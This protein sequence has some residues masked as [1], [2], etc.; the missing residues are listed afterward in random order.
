MLLLRKM[1]L[2]VLAMV[3]ILPALKSGA[4]L[5]GAETDMD[6]AQL[7]IDGGM[8]ECIREGYDFFED[9]DPYSCEL[10]CNEG[11]RDRLPLPKVCS[12]GDVNCTP[13]VK[14]ILVQWHEKVKNKQKKIV[15]A[16]CPASQGK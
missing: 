5:S 6:C 13:D 1:Q 7:I 2:V 14:S 12:G 15:K 3:L 9:Y 11:G 10:K 8:K 16:W 4:L